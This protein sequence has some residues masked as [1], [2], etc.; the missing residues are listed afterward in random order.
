M[1]TLPKKFNSRP[2]APTSHWRKA[3]VDL[4]QGLFISGRELRHRVKNYPLSLT[5]YSNSLVLE[6][7]ISEK[8]IF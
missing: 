3:A 2:V 4:S 7:L 6:L 5:N 1:R 8:E